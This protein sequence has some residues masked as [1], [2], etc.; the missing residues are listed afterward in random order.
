[1][2]A[3]AGYPNGFELDCIYDIG[4]GVASDAVEL[5]E[6][7]WGKIGVKLNLIGARGAAYTGTVGYPA[8]WKHVATGGA[9]GNVSPYAS[10]SAQ[11]HPDSDFDDGHFKKQFTLAKTEIDPVKRGAML[12][13]L[14]VHALDHVP[15]LPLGIPNVLQVW[16]PWVKNYYGEGWTGDYNSNYEPM[17]STL[18]IDQ[19]MKKDMGY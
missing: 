1:M 7:M 12:K 6:N 11:G 4:M 8:V 14:A 10:L 18:W 2:L 15:R 19:A 16:W 9:T 17:W 13:D 5:L 3:D